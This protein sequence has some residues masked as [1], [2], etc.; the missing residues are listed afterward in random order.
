MEYVVQFSLDR[1]CEG[2]NCWG[3]V[4]INLL[5][6]PLVL[7]DGVVVV[8]GGLGRLGAVLL[9]EMAPSMFGE[10]GGDV[11]EVVLFR[12]RLGAFVMRV[13]AVLIRVSR[14]RRSVH[15]EPYPSATLKYD[16]GV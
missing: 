13:A 5:G 12:K 16:G 10:L 9:V 11:G 6:W 8:E 15:S 7:E 3:H 4:P 2:E 1:F 14:P